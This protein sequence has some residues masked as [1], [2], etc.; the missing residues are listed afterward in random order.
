MAEGDT[1]DPP[2]AVRGN[3]DVPMAT[4][5]PPAT[6]SGATTAATRPDNGTGERPRILVTLGGGGYGLQGTLL[7]RLLAADA[8]LVYVTGE[9]G[10]WPAEVGLPPGP[11]LVVPYF[12]TA[13]AGSRWRDVWSALSI[14]WR[15]FRFPRANGPDCVVVVA[16]PQGLITLAVARLTRCPTVFIESVTRVTNPSL[17]LRLC[18][19]LRLAR[20]VYVQWPALESIVAGSEFKG[21]V[22]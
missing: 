18:R 8:D 4:G 16:M 3:L 19:R 6:E 13:T 22:F 1:D 14:T 2:L 7:A 15:S 20:H 10:R 11:Q 12:K 9:F 17:T 5:H 21:R